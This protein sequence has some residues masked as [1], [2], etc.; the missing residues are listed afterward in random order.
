MPAK[1]R[2]N[3]IGS[4]GTD[5]NDFEHYSLAISA[6]NRCGMCIDSDEKLLFQHGVKP[7]AI[8]AAARV[9]AVMKAPATVHATL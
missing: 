7:D 8:Q 2:M 1:L 9:G 3:T 5:K 6:I 4:H